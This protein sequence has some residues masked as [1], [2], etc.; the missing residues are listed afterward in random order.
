MERV[1]DYKIRFD[2]IDR[3]FDRVDQKFLL[4]GQILVDLQ[5]GQKRIEG[6]VDSLEC[7]VDS[8]EGKVDSLECKVDSLEG[9]VDSIE[10]AKWMPLLCTWVSIPSTINETENQQE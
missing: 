5:A 4:Q 6:K 8:L 1:E 2:E 9:K 3:R 7:K 10:G